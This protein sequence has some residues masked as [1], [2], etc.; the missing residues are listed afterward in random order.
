MSRGRGGEEGKEGLGDDG[1]ECWVSA[2][3][4]G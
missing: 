3:Q 1:E 4:E 2:G